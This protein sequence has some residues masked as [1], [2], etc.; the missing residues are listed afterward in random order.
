LACVLLKS[1]RDNFPAPNLSGQRVRFERCQVA[2]G[3]LGLR[4]EKPASSGRPDDVRFGSD[5][6]HVG[7]VA[8]KTMSG[9][10]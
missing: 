4:P 8:N 3:R 5:D 2:Q 7:V 6:P 9:A 10:V 1:A